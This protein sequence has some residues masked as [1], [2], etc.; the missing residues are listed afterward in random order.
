MDQNM[1]A[2]MTISG[3]KPKVTLHNIKVAETS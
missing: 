1:K 3:R 2:K